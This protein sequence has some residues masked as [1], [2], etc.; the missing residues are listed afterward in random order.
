MDL[1]HEETVDI[2]VSIDDARIIAKCLKIAKARKKLEA[3]QELRKG[4]TQL[5]AGKT[6]MV[7]KINQL[8]HYLHYLLK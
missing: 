7:N 2:R 6:E 4:F 8:E 5:S 1:F 3:N